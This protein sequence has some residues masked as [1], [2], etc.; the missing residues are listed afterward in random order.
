MNNKKNPR[1]IFHKKLY[2]DIYPRLKEFENLRLRELKRCKN[3]DRNGIVCILFWFIISF[4]TLPLIGD[5]VFFGFFIIA[6]IWLIKKAMIS[7]GFTK[8]IKSK[9]M[10]VLCEAFGNL[11]WLST[12]RF[13]DSIVECSNLVKNFNRIHHDDY[14]CGTYF[15]VPIEIAEVT[16]RRVT[17]SGKNRRSRTLFKGVIV[18]LD[19]NKNFSGNTVIL[20]DT[21]LHCQR[22][23]YLK[24]TELEDVEFEKKFDVYSSD[25]TEARYLI[26][27]TF[28]ERL[29]Q[30][31]TAFN[32]KAV[33]CAFYE[34]KL[35]LGLHTNKNLFDIATINKS[36]FDEAQYFT[37]FNEI[38][39]ILKLIKHFKL[40]TKIKAE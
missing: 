6:I 1:K 21:L 13:D 8:N 27:P 17:G 16:Y 23:G 10:P 25:P 36:L 34:N 15:D 40:D 2:E 19:I 31:Q 32:A 37:M 5:F 38:Y 3:I 4:F 26:T 35:I 18:K 30:V 14:F 24:H 12:S 39:S 22:G 9:I 7:M 28:M 29:K 20:P 11:Q 33:S